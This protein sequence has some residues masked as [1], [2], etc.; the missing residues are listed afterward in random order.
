MERS[1]AF[2]IRLI[3]NN[4][5]S[6][7]TGVDGEEAHLVWKV[8]A[9]KGTKWLGGCLLNITTGEYGVGGL[10]DMYVHQEERKQ[11]IGT[12]LAH[13]TCELAEKLGCHYVV[14]NATEEGEPVYRRAGFISMGKGHT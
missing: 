14:L 1:D 7:A 11:G 12:A 4:D 5:A 8:S 13:D 10:F 9:F 6:T 3:P 2:E